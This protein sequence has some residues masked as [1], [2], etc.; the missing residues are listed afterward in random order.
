[1]Q[2]WSIE[3]FQ[4]SPQQKR[5]WSLSNRGESQSYRVRGEILIEGNVDYSILKAAI[6][7][8]VNKA[9]IFRTSFQ[10]LPEMTVPLQAIKERANLEIKY[11]DLTALDSKKHKTAIEELLTQQK[12]IKFNLKKGDILAVNAVQISSWQHILIITLS[13]LCGDIISLYNFLNE[14]GDAYTN[15]LSQKE[16]LNEP[17][18][19]ADIAT[20]QNE[21]FEEN[22]LEVEKKYWHEQNIFDFTKI[23]LPYEREAQ[24][25][26]FCPRWIAINLDADILTKI[27]ALAKN[28]SVSIS[29]IL[30][31]CWQVLL[32]R[33]VGQSE[34]AIATYFDGR[35]YEELKSAF[36]LLAKYPPV[37]ITLDENE[38]FS[39]ILKQLEE[40]ISEV[41]RWQEFFNWDELINSNDY[42]PRTAKGDRELSFFPFAFEFISQPTKY[43]ID[44][45]SFSLQKLYAC[46]ERFKVKLS[47]W[48]RDNFLV[49]EL[50]YDANI[51]DR[52]DI[53]RLAAEFQ[54]ILK[55][56]VNCPETEISQLE[57]FSQKERQQLLVEFNHTNS[58]P[59]PYQCLHHWF[60]AQVNNTPNNIA[61]VFEDRKLT[62][63]QL[64][65]KADC[66]ANS[67]A[68]LG[69][70]PE[71]I[72][73]L[74]VERSPYIPVGILGILKAGGAYLPLEPSLPLEALAFRLQDA[75]VSVL[76]TQ[77]HLT[78]TIK[79]LPIVAQNKIQIVCL[80]ES[81]L[82]LI[83]M[84]ENSISPQAYPGRGADLTTTS[85]NLAYVIYTSG[86][87][88]K[89]KGVAVEHRQVI[90]Y[91][92]GILERLNLPVGASFATVSTFAADLGNTVIFSAL[93]SGGCL[94]IIAEE[95]ATDPVALADYV[96]YHQID[97]LKIVPSH[98]SALLTHSHPEQ[99][100][101]RQRLIL[102]G[103]A[104]TWEL[105]NQIHNLAP[106]CQIFNH[107]GPTETTI[108]VLTNS[109][110]FKPNP[111]YATV[112]LGRPLANSQIY[113]LD[114]HQKPV[115]IGVAGEIYIGGE[116]V[117]RGYL[118]RPKLTA[119]RFIKNPFNNCSEARLY[120]TGD[121]ARFHRDGSLEFLGRVDDQIKLNGFRIE[122]GE[123]EAAL[124][125]HPKIK[126]VVVLARED[127]LS[128][129]RLVAY[130]VFQD[131]SAQNKVNDLRAFLAE[132]LPE[133][134]LP[135]HFVPLK[136]LPLTANGKIDRQALPAPDEVKPEIQ[137]FVAP[138]TPAEIALAKIWSELLGVEKVSIHD[139]FFELGGDSIISIQAIARANQVGLRLTPKQIF[140]HQ[141][142][143]KLAANAESS[144]KIESKQGLI[145]GSVPLTPI[146][147]SFFEQDLPQ[148]HHWNQSVLLE[149]KQDIDAKLLPKALHCL[150]QHHDALRMRFW[151]EANSWQAS[152]GDSNQQISFTWLDLSN[153]SEEN[154][155]AAIEA[156]SAQVQTSLNLLEGELVK[157]VLFDLGCDF[158]RKRYAD[159][160]NRLLIVIHHLIVD[161]VSWRILLSDFQ[162]IIE[163]LNQSKIVQLPAKTTSF[164]QWSESLQEYERAKTLHSELDYWRSQAKKQISPLPKD[165]PQGANTVAQTRIVSVFLS[166]AETQA[167]LQQVPAKYQTQMNDVLL[168]AL[169]Q[170]FARWTKECTLLVNLE[171]HGREDIISGVDLSRTVGW[172]T[173][174]FPVL[175]N[176]EN[177][178][179]IGDALKSIKE[180]LRSIPNRGIGYG[181]LKYLSRKL[182]ISD[183]VQ[184]EVCFNY[185]GQF[186][187]V[188]PDSSLFS[189]APESYGATR[190]PLGN[191]RYLIDINGFVS[192]EKL[193]F[194]WAYSQE[195]HQEATISSLAQGFIETLRN[196]I[197]HCQSTEAGGYTPS[198]FPQANLNQKE[199]DRFLAKI[200]QRSENKG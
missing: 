49:T 197:T 14:I 84:G 183:S 51:F 159:R 192:E 134:M 114:S 57:I 93:C 128:C 27:E 103:E 125:Q 90:N 13:S 45:I 148:P 101:P 200:S 136:A 170:T 71:S 32:W 98:L 180:Q 145:T 139:N 175:L 83:T 53:E 176:L 56:A 196:I 81:P 72:V 194:N 118:N 107:Y 119:E 58:N 6:Q 100:L 89:P 52:V 75:K 154:R 106:N 66:I 97:C 44:N 163:Q 108:G 77:K 120:R 25:L 92:S 15:C 109:I 36:G 126:N 22:K 73:A 50:H 29:T 40:K 162:T 184:P 69:V 2:S 5:L 189:F 21:L 174:V 41:G 199:L 26:E 160:K 48:Y 87:T 80:D 167:L 150:L 39:E 37:H 121:L 85:K 169:V 178:S 173:T 7:E 60:E 132:K 135:S 42:A 186:D 31:A 164:K 153:L 182:S 144:T 104:S 179:F 61:V 18:Q 24:E 113:L 74:C 171:G 161:S 8:V 117:A 124:H 67:L 59:P 3:G 28:N 141:T 34:I 131:N 30:M 133:Y 193:E 147:R 188:L 94:H 168:T 151:Q 181:V 138:T 43:C 4:I 1:M 99:I 19:Y 129:K 137:G 11:N 62:Y 20:W 9:E 46:I 111:K 65:I 187:R 54:T 158:L 191:R 190:S 91:L 78:D 79:Q 146:Q 23:Q 47:C 33:L 17:L 35:N 110:D 198:D 166:E 152:I 177:T 82:T 112:P 55:S 105:I 10:I 95:K 96:R 143:A 16:R 155:T 76:L 142:I 116:S 185:L 88:G 68:S 64:N 70:K 86:S 127:K 195:I 165:Y 156:T 122:L 157:V 130:L 38:K 140:E 102:G 12:Q 63:Q 149:L 172:F 123:I 115:P